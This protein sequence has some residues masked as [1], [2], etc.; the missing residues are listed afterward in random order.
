MIRLE[1][2]LN[3]VKGIVRNLKCVEVEIVVLKI[4]YF[5]RINKGFNIIIMD[6]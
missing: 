3:K 2:L 4:F 6:L 5:K 1:E